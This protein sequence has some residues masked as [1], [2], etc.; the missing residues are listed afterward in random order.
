[1]LSAVVTESSLSGKVAANGA[2]ARTNLVG[3]ND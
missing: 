2:T 3:L 1:M